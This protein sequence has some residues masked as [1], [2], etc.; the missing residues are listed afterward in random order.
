MATF[1]YLCV[2]LGYIYYGQWQ[3]QNREGYGVLKRADK[4]VYIGCW[5]SN[6]KHGWGKLYASSGDLIEQGEYRAGQL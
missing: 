2:D 5:H 6:A 3:D 4:E 1:T